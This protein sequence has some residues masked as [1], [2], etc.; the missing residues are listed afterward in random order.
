MAKIHGEWLLSTEPVYIPVWGPP[1][2]CRKQP[3]RGDRILTGGRGLISFHPLRLVF[4]YDGVGVKR[5]LIN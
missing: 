4:H 5:E 2:K 3:L 1:Q